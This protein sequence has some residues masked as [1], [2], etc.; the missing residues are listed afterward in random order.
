MVMKMD[1]RIIG[2]R[3]ASA[4]APENTIEAFALAAEM[5]AGGVELDVYLTKDD[6]LAVHHDR[7]I[8]RMTNGA[9][10]GF[11]EELT[12]DELKRH[13]YCGRFPEKYPDAHLP[14]LCEVYSLMKTHNMTVN[15]ELMMASD[16]PE[17]RKRYMELLCET[18]AL[19]GMEDSIIYSSFSVANL[20]TMR[21]VN[22]NAYTALL[23]SNQPEDITPWDY[24]GSLGCRAVHPHYKRVLEDGKTLVEN[25]HANG[26]KVHP[27]TA[28]DPDDIRIL[29][30]C[31]VDAIITNYPDVL[32]K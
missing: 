10:F 23:Y 2:H 7:S 32:S 21:E 18:A 4:Y 9:D 13:S 22:P 12:L 20:V 27:W 1:K 15:T 16:D 19:T 11:V 5:G 8:A 30:E 3:G 28:D 24:A 25:C 31:G 14:E 26:I 6:R 29:L 17:R